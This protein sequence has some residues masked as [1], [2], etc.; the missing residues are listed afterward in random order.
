M[1]AILSRTGGGGGICRYYLNQQRN[2]AT[3]VHFQDFTVLGSYQDVAVAKRYGTYGGVVLQKQP[4]RVPSLQHERK[5][6]GVFCVSVKNGQKKVTFRARCQDRPLDGV[7]LQAPF[8]AVIPQ[9]HYSILPSG[10]KPLQ[11]QGRHMLQRRN[12]PRW[13][14]RRSPFSVVLGR[15]LD[16]KHCM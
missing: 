14:H 2:G 5:Q 9:G 1:T 8:K 10:H 13:M 15:Q 11:A 6:G 3:L 7:G 12:R 4:C 16:E